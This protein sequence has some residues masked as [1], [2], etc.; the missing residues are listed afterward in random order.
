[1]QTFAQNGR[2]CYTRA[3]SIFNQKGEDDESKD[4]RD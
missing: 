1:M 2:F 3:V 4:Y